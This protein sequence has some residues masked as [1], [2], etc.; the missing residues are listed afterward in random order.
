MAL[1]CPGKDSIRL[2][3]L[4]VVDLSFERRKVWLILQVG[5]GGGGMRV[6]V[7]LLNGCQYL[8]VTSAGIP[9]VFS[10]GTNDVGFAVTSTERGHLGLEAWEK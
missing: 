7:D 1:D 6:Q 10:L 8:C 2:W 9:G 5:E 4:Q 3:P